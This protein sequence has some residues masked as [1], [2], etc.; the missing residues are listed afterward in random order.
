[1]KTIKLMGELIL[2]DG[3]SEEFTVLHALYDL[4]Y[5]DGDINRYIIAVLS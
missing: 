5:A 2:K 3:L 4:I 1:M